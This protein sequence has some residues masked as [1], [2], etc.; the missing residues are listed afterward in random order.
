MGCFLS[1]SF[2]SF[3][4]ATAIDP[5]GS[6]SAIAPHEILNVDVPLHPCNGRYFHFGGTIRMCEAES[7]ELTVPTGKEKGDGVWTRTDKDSP[8]PRA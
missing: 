6:I 5:C 7:F 8:S 4:S 1:F 3:Y 2:F